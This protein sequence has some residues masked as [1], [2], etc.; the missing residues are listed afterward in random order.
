[1]QEKQKM[2]FGLGLREF[3]LPIIGFLS[4]LIA[5]EPF[6]QNSIDKEVS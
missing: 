4:I 6:W 1:M 5:E 2:G 3:S